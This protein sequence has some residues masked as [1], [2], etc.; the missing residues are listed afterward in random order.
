MD[1]RYPACTASQL[2]DGSWKIP[3]P[4]TEDAWTRLVFSNQNPNYPIPE[5]APSLTPTIWAPGQTFNNI[6]WSDPQSLNTELCACKKGMWGLTFDDGPSSVTPGLLDFLRERNAKA[7]FFVVGAN[8]VNEG[9]NAEILRRAYEEGHQIGYH[10]W[11][12][13]PMTTLTTDQMVTEIVWSAVAIYRVIGHVPRYFRPPYGDIDDRLRN[14][15]VAMGLRP[16]VWTAISDDADIPDSGPALN[17]WS[18]PAMISRFQSIISTG[19]QPGLDWVPPGAPYEGHI[20][21]HHDIR[22]SNV[23]A[24]R[25]IVPVVLD[26]GFTT[27]TVAECEQRDFGGAYLKDGE[28]LLRLVRSIVDGVTD[29]ITNVAVTE[30]NTQPPS[31]TTEPASPDSAAGPVASGNEGAPTP[32]TPTGSQ[33][34][35]TGA[36]NNGQPRGSLPTSA[37]IGAGA[38]AF[39]VLIA[40]LLYA[41][42]RKQRGAKKHLDAEHGIP[43]GGSKCELQDMKPSISTTVTAEREE[44]HPTDVP[45]EISSGLTASLPRSAMDAANSAVLTMKQSIKSV[46]RSMSIV[47]VRTQST[48]A[49]ASDD[50][51]S[52]EPLVGARSISRSKS[53]NAT[54]LS[55]K[56]SLAASVAA[57]SAEEGV[58]RVPRRN[59]TMDERVPYVASPVLVPTIL[60]VASR[61]EPVDFVL[62]PESF[63]LEDE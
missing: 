31:P 4:P 62:E 34:S 41:Y 38:G 44:I 17:N 11:T 22:R 63:D 7:T 23:D 48:H 18:I 21:L 15:L 25:Q 37:F 58:G 26:G 9:G 8:I 52:V 16:V 2:P 19:S 57:A 42:Y 32:P 47:S 35:Q 39:V 55:R 3:V 27:V 33:E 13:H 49:A 50:P 59:A 43:E 1:P 24:A 36:T 14:V 56:R 20:S 60:G 12:H 5:T 28:M 46:G 51:A 61:S 45:I 53:T 40:S 54:S 29:P 10:S 30:S 6:P